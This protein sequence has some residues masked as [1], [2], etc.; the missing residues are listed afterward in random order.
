MRPWL[1]SLRSGPD[2]RL[3]GKIQTPRAAELLM[4]LMISGRSQVGED[5]EPA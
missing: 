1:N 5:K 2:C 3:R 4:Q